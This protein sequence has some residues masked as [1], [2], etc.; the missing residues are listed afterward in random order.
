MMRPEAAPNG[1]SLSSASD[2]ELWV[3]VL[4]GQDAAFGELFDRHHQAIYNFCFRR[5]A[6]RTAAEDLLST[7]F[8]HA[9]RRRADLRLE[10]DTILPWLYGIA[11]NLTRR[12][13]RGLGRRKAA[14]ARLPLVRPVPDPADEVVERLGEEVEAKRAL[15]RLRSLPE[16]DQ[17]L[18]VLCVWQ[19]LTYA[20]AA[21][22]LA[23]PVGSVRSR[24]SRAR[25]RLAME[26]RTPGGD[27]EGES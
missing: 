7:T 18:F 15:A 22:A 6:D 13:L 17:E 25:S 26:L 3:L 14:V 20:E 12:H 8:L 21:T 1:L 19:G 24:L 5:T 11:A 4:A 27:E 16:R 2:A 9:W 10:G 23:I